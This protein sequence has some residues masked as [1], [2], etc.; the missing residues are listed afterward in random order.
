MTYA[1]TQEDYRD[2]R[3]MERYSCLAPDE[4]DREDAMSRNDFERIARQLEDEE[5]YKSIVREEMRMDRQEWMIERP[6]AFAYEREET[7]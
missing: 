4:Q 7:K 6:R 1:E 3:R 5:A 2:A